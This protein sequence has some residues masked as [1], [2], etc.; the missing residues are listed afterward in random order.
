MTAIAIAM[1]LFVQDQDKTQQ[2][3]QDLKDR[4]EKLEK[5]KQGG[6]AGQNALNPTIAVIGNFL[7]RM[8]ND[9]VIAGDGVTELDDKVLVREVELDLRAAIDPYADGMLVLT[10]EA[11]TPGTFEVDVEELHVRI[12][13]LPFGFWEKPPLGTKITLGRFRTQIGRMNVLH[14]HDLPS[15]NRPRVI[16]EFL[17]EEGQIGDGAW[18][19]FFLP[20]PGDTA[21]ELHLQAMQGG[22]AGICQESD[23]PCYLANLAFF[24]PISDEFSLNASLI[25]FLGKNTDL[26]GDEGANS[27]VVSLDALFKWKPLRQGEYRSF[28]FGAQVMKS[29]SHEFATDTDLDGIADVMAE[30]KPLGWYAWAQYQFSKEI[31]VGARYDF[32][33]FLTNDDLDRSTITAYVSYYFSEFFRVRLAVERTTSDDPL[34]D[35]LLTSLFEVNVV[36]GAHPPHPFWVNK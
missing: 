18:L 35:E 19:Q 5:E 13:S 25:F 26:T 10:F 30:T 6:A 11:E 21:L 29:L 17:G 8:D 22:N 2:E 3:L 32:T 23:E 12:K 20:S 16:Q 27:E 7:W 24:W 1:L 15:P 9:D 34:E 33:E 36:F 28:I 31:Y 4:I 14:L